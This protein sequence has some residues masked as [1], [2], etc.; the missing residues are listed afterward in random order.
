[1]A[2]TI[3]RC[4][5][6]VTRMPSGERFTN[7]AN[8]VYLADL[9]CLRLAECGQTSYYLIHHSA[10]WIR[11]PHKHCIVPLFSLLLYGNTYNCIWPLFSLVVYGNTQHCIV[12]LFSLVVYGNTQHS[13]LC[14]M[15][16]HITQPCAIR[17]HTA[18]SLV[19]YGNTQH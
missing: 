13:A 18:L 8:L 15:A 3:L 1:M 5:L 2:H 4:A 12:H 9:G 19:V 6:H 10:L 7:C 17:Q 11:A 14:Y 16:T